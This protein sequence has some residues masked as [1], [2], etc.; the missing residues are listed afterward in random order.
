MLQSE[1]VARKN[2]ALFYICNT[3]FFRKIH[4]YPRFSHTI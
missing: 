3:S 2:F 1:R 4:S